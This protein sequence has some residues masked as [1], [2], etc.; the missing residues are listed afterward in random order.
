MELPSFRT[1]E[2]PPTR[3]Y[4]DMS[5][6]DLA[7]L[8]FYAVDVSPYE[9]LRYEYGPQGTN[10]DIVTHQDNP[11]LFDVVVYPDGQVYYDSRN[12]V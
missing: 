5:Y 8:D 4:A 3:V 2:G 11:K 9:L 6:A 7:D 10:W 12:A 1:Y